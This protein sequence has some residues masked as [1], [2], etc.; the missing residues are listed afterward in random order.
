MELV[1]EARHFKVTEAIE[2]HIREKIGKLDKYF[3]GIH[4]MHVVLDIGKNQMQTV[5]LIC[6]VAK[7]H[8]LVATGAAT[9]L[10]PAIDQAEKKIL[11]EMKKYK[12]KLRTVVRGKRGEEVAPVAGEAEA[13]GEEA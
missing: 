4:R 1:I 2:T 10:Y 12:A 9:D 11:V 8:T 3:D 6:T 5:E 7:R 13:E